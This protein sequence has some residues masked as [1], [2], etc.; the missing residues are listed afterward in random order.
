MLSD[1]QRAR[2]N[3][4]QL[5]IAEKWEKE[6]EDMG[7]V[8]EKLGLAMKNHDE[9]LWKEALEESN[10]NPISSRCDHDRSIWSTCSACDEIEH[11]LNPEFYDENGDRLE[12]E[13]IEK[14]VN[15]R[16]H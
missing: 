4:E 1:E 13:E 12:D 6:R 9:N 3:P 2:L 15:E 11:L 5:L 10:I 14:I 8:F 7:Q 16:G